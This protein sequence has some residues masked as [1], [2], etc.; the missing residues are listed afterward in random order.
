MRLWEGA[1]LC[2][3]SDITLH[4]YQ[5]E[6]DFD[7]ICSPAKIRAAKIDVA[8]INSVRVDRQFQNYIVGCE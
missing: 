7:M 4:V 8:S 2:A 1:I 5:N 6:Y 3:P